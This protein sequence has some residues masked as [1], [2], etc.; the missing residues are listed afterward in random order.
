MNT[1]TTC[2]LFGLALLAGGLIAT[3]AQA[4]IFTEDFNSYTGNQ[5]TTQADTGLEV[6]FGGNVAGWS[7]SGAGVIHAVDLAQSVMER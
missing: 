5:N 4:A 2:K 1:T 7:T 3:S 6:A